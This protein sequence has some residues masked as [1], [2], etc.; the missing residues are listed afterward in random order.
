MVSLSA[1]SIS[2][3]FVRYPEFDMALFHDELSMLAPL[4]GASGVYCF[5]SDARRIVSLSILVGQAFINH[6]ARFP[7]TL[8]RYFFFSGYIRNCRCP[9]L[10]VVLYSLHL[11]CRVSSFRVPP[12]DAFSPDAYRHDCR[13]AFSRR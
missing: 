3:P 5:E 8:I 4:N 6:S 2:S 12:L 11:Q 1:S 10:G 9:T 7:S 13:G